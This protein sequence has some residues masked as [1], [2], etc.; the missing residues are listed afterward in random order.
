MKLW[1][2]QNKHLKLDDSKRMIDN[3]THSFYLNADELDFEKVKRERLTEAYKRVWKILGTNQ[4]LWCFTD[5]EVAKEANGRDWTENCDLLEIDIPEENVKLHCAMAWCWILDRCGTDMP[6]KFHAHWRRLESDGCKKA[7]S[8][9][10]E[11]KNYWRDKA[12]EELWSLFL[13]P[14]FEPNLVKVCVLAIIV[15][16]LPV[17]CNVKKLTQDEIN[18]RRS[19]NLCKIPCLSVKSSHCSE[20][21]KQAGVAIYENSD[22]YL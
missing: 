10:E 2:W 13:L 15:L 7:K 1:T 5:K 9:E 17:N 12:K 20:C 8:Y 14:D 22:G 3:R 18:F 21:L 6:E 19:N 11:F 16:P 4:I